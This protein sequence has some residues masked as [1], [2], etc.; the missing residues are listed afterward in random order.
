[1]LGPVLVS[2]HNI[3]FFQRL[4][5]DIRRVIGEGLFDQ[6]RQTDP[7]AAQGPRDDKETAES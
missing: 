4:M 3:R 5:A 7:R 6:W 1:M 2:V